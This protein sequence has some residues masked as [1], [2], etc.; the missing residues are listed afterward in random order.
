M[1]ILIIKSQ[2]KHIIQLFKMI[3]YLE[4]GAEWL[5]R[6]SVLSN[7]AYRSAEV[8]EDLWHCGGGGGGG[9]GAGDGRAVHQPGDGVLFSTVLY[10]TVLYINQVMVEQLGGYLSRVS[11]LRLEAE[12]LERLRARIRAA[13][14]LSRSF[15]FRMLAKAKPPVGY[16]LCVIV[17]I[18]F[19]YLTLSTRRRPSL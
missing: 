17:P 3:N 1:L 8:P 12:Q 9:G 4:K 19:V 13:T 11:V 10:C 5:P 15:T 7:I 16:Y 14:E 6:I 18:C 2:R